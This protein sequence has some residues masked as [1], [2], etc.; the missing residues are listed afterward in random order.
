[1][2]RVHEALSFMFSIGPRVRGGARPARKQTH[3]EVT[4]RRRLASRMTD[5][6]FSSF[7][8][9]MWSSHFQ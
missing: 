8:Q 3:E 7:S 6:T 9:H 5:C 4:I 1:M 2:V